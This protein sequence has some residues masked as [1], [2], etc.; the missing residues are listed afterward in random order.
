[1]KIKMNK[2]SFTGLRVR[3]LC[4]ILTVILPLAGMIVY[5]STED[6]NRE[7]LQV[8]RQTRNLTRSAS[9]L[10]ERTILEARQILFTLSQVPQIRQQDPDAASKILARL[11]RET[12]KYTGFTTIKPNGEIFASAPTIDQPVNFYDRPWFQRLV[13]TRDFVIGD[14]LL[15]RALYSLQPPVNESL[16]MRTTAIQRVLFTRRVIQCKLFYDPI[17]NWP[18]H[19]QTCRYLGLSCP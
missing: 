2:I 15:M 3:L 11:L 6:R 9:I 18:Y 17:N 1:V 16:K 19:R 8:L 7:R 10:F 4:I 14:Y 13:Q 12:K 5:H